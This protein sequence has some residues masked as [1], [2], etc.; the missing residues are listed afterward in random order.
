LSRIAAT[1]PEEAA[2]VAP[3]IR[4]GEEEYEAQ[5]WHEFYFGAW[6][7]LRYDRFYGAFGG[8][9][10][11]SYSAVGRY[12]R[13][14]GLAGEQVSVFRALLSAIDEEWL[15]HVAEKLKRKPPP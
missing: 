9:T 14:H 8:E 3:P 11:I 5:S 1:Y 10:P 13:D 7:S 4:D 12:A 2:L 6:E 15:G